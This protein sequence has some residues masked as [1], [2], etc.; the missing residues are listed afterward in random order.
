MP[1][2]ATHLIIALIFGSLIR[3]YFVKDKK[4]FPLHYVLILALASLLPDLDFLVYWVSYALGFSIPEV[5]R[6]FSHNLFVPAIFF[7]LS[8]VTLKLKNK[9][10]GKHHLKI[11]TLFWII[12]LGILIHLALDASIAGTVMPFYPISDYSLGNEITSNFPEPLDR[13][14]WPCLDAALIVL[15]LVYLEW[16]HKISDFI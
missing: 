13:I 8:L 4:K 6:T 2:A 14:F 10:L 15:W 16:K 1:Y 12:G 9:S 5:H 11:H 7:L 3:D